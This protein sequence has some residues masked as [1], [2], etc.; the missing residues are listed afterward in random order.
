MCSWWPAAGPANNVSNRSTRY[1]T[2]YSQHQNPSGFVSKTGIRPGWSQRQQTC[3]PREGS[4][5]IVYTTYLVIRSLARRI[6]GLDAEMNE[7][8]QALHSLFTE[9]APTLLELHGVGVD[10]AASLLVTAGDNPDRLHTENFV[11]PPMWGRTNPCQ[12]GESDS[13]SAQP[14]RRPPR[15]FCALR[16]VLTRMSSHS[17]TKTYVNRRREGGLSTPEIVRCLKRYVARETFKHL[18]VLVLGEGLTL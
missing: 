17:E 15:Q 14:G 9:T 2:W 4:D 11:G 16:I 5:P 3:G 1:V 12:L 8:D 18:A 6:K 7:I 13:T 10:T